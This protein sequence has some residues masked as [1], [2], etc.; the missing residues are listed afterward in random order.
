MRRSRCHHD[1]GWDATSAGATARGGPRAESPKQVEPENGTWDHKVQTFL[2]RVECFSPGQLY[3]MRRTDFMTKSRLMAALL[4][5]GICTT[6][7]VCVQR[8]NCC[9]DCA[10]VRWIKLYDT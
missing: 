8:H 3:K 7:Y 6:T 2:L 9:D 1:D 5:K 10:T 4:G